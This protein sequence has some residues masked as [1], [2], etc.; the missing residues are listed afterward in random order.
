M[1]GQVR[2]HLSEVPKCRFAESCGE[3][4]DLMDLWQG[5]DNVVMFDAVVNQ[6]QPGRT[7][8]RSGPD[9]S[10][11]LFKYSSRAFIVAEEV[12]LA[13]TLGNLSQKMTV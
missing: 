8:S 11:R 4:T 13:R 1:L 2:A 5:Y 9:L 12:E 7:Y 3:G 10:F 6:G